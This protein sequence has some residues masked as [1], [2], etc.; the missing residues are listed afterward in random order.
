MPSAYSME[1]AS[2]ACALLFGKPC[3]P[4]RRADSHVHLGI[5]RR[6]GRQHGCL[7]SKAQVSDAGVARFGLAHSIIGTQTKRLG[8]LGAVLVAVAVVAMGAPVMGNADLLDGRLG[9]GLVSGSARLTIEADG[10]GRYGIALRYGEPPADFAQPLPLAVEVV[11]ENGDARRIEAPYA[12]IAAFWVDDGEFRCAGVVRTEAGTEFHFA[13]VYTAHDESGAFRLRRDV[14]VRSPADDDYGFSTRFSLP[15]LSPAP[16]TGYDF[17]APGIWYGDNKN[18]PE[19][20][21]A[22]DYSDEDF[23]FRETRLTAPFVMMREKDSGLTAVLAHDRP[24]A[25]TFAKDDFAKRIIDER[26]QY[27]ALGVRKSPGVSLGLLFPGS[28]GEKTYIGGKKPERRWASRSHPVKT[29]VTHRYD[30]I[31]AVDEFPNYYEALKATWRRFYEH[32]KPPRI[33]ADIEKVYSDGVDLLLRYCKE[34]NGAT[35]VPFTIYMNGEVKGSAFRLGFTG[36]HALVAYHLVRY[37]LDRDVPEAIDKGRAMLD[38]WTSD[39]YDPA[40]RDNKEALPY[41]WH[42]PDTRKWGRGAGTQTVFPRMLAEGHRAI[43]RTWSLT[44]DCAETNPEWLAYAK[45]FGDWLCR[46]QAPDGSWFRQYAVDGTATIRSKRNTAY[47]IPFLLDL[48]AVT[49]DPAYR[50]AA[51]RAGE[52]AWEHEHLPGL[53]LEGTPHLLDRMDKEAPL[54]ALESHLA[55][56][57]FTGEA[58]WLEAA[59][60]AATFAETWTY[61]WNVPMRP[62]DAESQWPGGRHTAGLSLVGTGL[63][64]A[65]YYN[66]FGARSYYKLY[67]LT[68]D[69][70]F[71]EFARL[72]LHNTKQLLDT[73]GSQGHAHPGLQVEGL[74]LA[75]RRGRGPG[76]W[77]P[78]VTI[79]HIDPIIRLRDEFGSTDLDP[80]HALPRPPN[81]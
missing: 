40:L 48:Y 78:W 15:S 17:F 38:F 49:Q 72:S 44:R 54:L 51:L 31:I 5:L 22:G 2:H 30:I 39:S 50:D 6:P 64:Y 32:Y 24:G 35:G 26:M 8:S 1:C 55:L 36:Q 16:M 46:H 56:H 12:R 14:E 10:D 71:R 69:E 61:V 70:H 20:S 68:G 62:G 76:V 21:L 25:Q 67:R 13:D 59:E 75:V 74:T 42:R 37:G 23:F 81:R 18:V 4:R 27:A 33:K 11:D 34:T 43:L 53:Y 66:A 77:L 57:E 60:K 28:E 29:G 7:D 47:P 65:D 58:K 79:A 73:D 19:G 45:R 80:I 63:S 41:T 3:F 52:F 9:A